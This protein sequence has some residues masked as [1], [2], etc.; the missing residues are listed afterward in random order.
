ME[1]LRL[2]VGLMALLS[3]AAFFLT[4]RLFRRASPVLLD[5]VAV[6]VVALIGVYLRTV[7][8]QLWVVNWIPLPSVIVLSNWFP[9]F[10]AILS[11]VLWLRMAARPFLRRAPIQLAL[12]VSAACSVLYVIPR[13]PPACRNE[14][15]E[16]EFPVT[17]RICRQTSDPPVTCSAAAAATL[18]AALGID[19]NE[20]EMARLC[21]T[22][23]GTTWLGM[24][25]GLSIKLMGTG[26]KAKFFEGTLAQLAAL[27]ADRPVLL[28][29]ELSETVA[30]MVPEYRE[31][32]GWIPGVSHTVVCFG[33]KNGTFFIGDPSQP[34]LERW[35]HRRMIDLWTGTGLT[36]AP[37]SDKSPVAPRG[38]R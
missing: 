23:G 36:I 5:L 31:A 33:E 25:H 18:L 30:A 4:V 38:V 8:G 19:A 20:A 17:F 14:W 9:I 21:L 16:P 35:D 22:R 28:C 1:H 7:W 11:A 24:Y 6:M 32:D 34:S 29:C 27:S 10:L 12:L 15:I 26:L 13:S 3:V 37:L 2:A